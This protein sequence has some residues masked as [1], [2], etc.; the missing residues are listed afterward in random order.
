MAAVPWSACRR[1]L[2]RFMC[3]E[4][5][6]RRGNKPHLTLTHLTSKRVT[7]VALETISVEVGG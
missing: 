6:A 5:E 1:A 4:E 3:T 2:A 7:D